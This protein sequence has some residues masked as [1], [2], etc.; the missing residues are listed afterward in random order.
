MTMIDKSFDGLPV[1]LMYVGEAEMGKLFSVTSQLFFLGDRQFLVDFASEL[2]HPRWLSQSRLGYYKT[3]DS[4]SVRIGNGSETKHQIA[5][6]LIFFRRPQDDSI[7]CIS[8]PVSMVT[9]HDLYM[10]G[11]LKLFPH[12][13]PCS[14]YCHSDNATQYGFKYWATEKVNNRR[15]KIKKIL[16][17]N[18]S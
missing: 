12:I 7:A 14:R 13:D 15:S 2:S 1:E 18:Q 8:T 9:H 4:I 10:E 17:E 5:A 3:V 16:S 6:E 11:V